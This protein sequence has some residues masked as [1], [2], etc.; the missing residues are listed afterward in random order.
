MVLI[1]TFFHPSIKTLILVEI[2]ITT[3]ATLAD[4]YARKRDGEERFAKER[5]QWEEVKNEY[6]PLGNLPAKALALYTGAPGQLKEYIQVS[7]LDGIKAMEELAAGLPIRRQYAEQIALAENLVQGAR[8]KLWATTT[9]APSTLWEQGFSYFNA[10]EKIQAREK[11]RLVIMRHQTLFDDYLKNREK[12]DEYI[13]WHRT[14]GFELKFRRVDSWDDLEA[15]IGR[16]VNDNNPLTDFVIKDDEFVYGR[17]RTFRGNEVELKYISHSE[18]ANL[19]Q[20]I[21]YSSLFAG[22]WRQ[23][24]TVEQTLL[25]LEEEK[26]KDALQA[27]TRKDYKTEFES[28]TQGKDFFNAVCKRISEAKTS[29]IA[30]DMADIKQG[31]ERW[32][33]QPEY[34]G[35][36]E[37]S[38][39]A[40]Q[41]ANEGFQGKRLYIVKE[42]R[43]LSSLP[44]RRVLQEQ[45]DAG[46]EVIILQSRE[47]ATSDLSIDDFILIDEDFGFRLGNKPNSD[48]SMLELELGK[49]LIAKA[50][51]KDFRTKFNVFYEHP[52]AKK[53]KGPSQKDNFENFLQT[54]DSE[55]GMTQQSDI[56]NAVKE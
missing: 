8:E 12:F 19:D 20:F 35:F 25:W 36:L 28:V 53:F 33:W 30:V 13:E 31:V 17:T 52:S 56:P 11:R 6:K 48:F 45:I 39:H 46:L 51:L 4:V 16:T 32:S 40:A 55:F 29:L 47:A 41:S 18:S 23:A 43:P 2:C 44:L 9:D 24:D 37:A 10:Q 34:V 38:I 15:H 1:H 21:R 7:V 27:Q 50:R 49:N 14:Y 22:L 5:R 26:D 54:L 42:F 3:V